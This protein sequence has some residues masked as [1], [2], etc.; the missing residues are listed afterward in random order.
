MTE[1]Q[2]NKETNHLTRTIRPIHYRNNKFNPLLVEFIFYFNFCENNRK[3]KE[4]QEQKITNIKF[5]NPINNC[6]KS[7]K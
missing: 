2:K 3:R 7:R 6:T 4:T 5:S 1:E